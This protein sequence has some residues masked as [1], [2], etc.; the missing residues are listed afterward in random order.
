MTASK[1]TTPVTC[2]F[3]TFVGCRARPAGGMPAWGSVA[4]L[5]LNTSI[6]PLGIALDRNGLINAFLIMNLQDLIPIGCLASR[7]LLVWAL[8]AASCG[9]FGVVHFGALVYGGRYALHARFELQGQVAGVVPRQGEVAAVEP[10]AVL[11]GR[12]PHVAQLALPRARVLR[13][14]RAESP[15][16]PDLVGHVL[17]DDAGGQLIHGAVARRVDDEVGREPGAV[18]EDHLVLGQ[19][20]HLSLGQLDVAVGDGVAGTDVDVVAG[21]AAQVLEEQ[22]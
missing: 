9:L 2:G 12:F 1:R 14:A 5:N 17:A 19:L 22:A 16:L 20:G 3:L 4:A 7:N 15:D 6:C 11:G 10:Q 8:R 18:T 21:T 13:R